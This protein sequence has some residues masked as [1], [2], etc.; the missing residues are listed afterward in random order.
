MHIIHI[1]RIHK[2]V[3]C[4]V[5]M[6]PRCVEIW[7]NS[8]GEGVARGRGV[9]GRTKALSTST[10]CQVWRPA[11]KEL[12]PLQQASGSLHEE[13]WAGCNESFSLKISQEVGNRSG[14]CCHGVLPSISF[15]CSCATWAGQ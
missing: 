11:V 8:V 5:C 14:V 2:H 1:D 10:L 4:M 7:K 13:A 3:P 6:M 15:L 9:P 12:A